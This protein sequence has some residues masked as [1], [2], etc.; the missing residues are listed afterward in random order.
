MSNEPESQPPLLL[1]AHDQAAVIA[2]LIRA[3]RLAEAIEQD[4]KILADVTARLAAARTARAKG[5]EALTIFGF[6]NQ[7][8]LWARVQ[9]SIGIE[10]YMDAY[11]FA[12][13]Y[14]SGQEMPAVAE[15]EA[16]ALEV[17]MHEEGARPNV[18]A[19]ILEILERAG[20]RGASVGDVKSQLE[21]DYGLFLHDKTPGMTLYRLQKQ[22]KVSRTGRIWSI[23]Q[24]VDDSGNAESKPR[25]G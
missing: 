18:A 16:P 5:I 23:T 6:E 7:L 25:E 1:D 13:G 19:A 22:G 15:G 2:I 21:T 24:P 14:P 9:E 20:L 12:R 8:G 3:F 17:G 4:E 10:T 11:N